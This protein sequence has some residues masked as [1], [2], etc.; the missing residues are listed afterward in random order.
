MEE[1][2]KTVTPVQY[3]KNVPTTRIIVVYNNDYYNYSELILII[4]LT[5]CFFRAEWNSVWLF[6][7]YDS[8]TVLYLCFKQEFLLLFSKD[9]WNKV[10]GWLKNRLKR[11]GDEI[12]SNKI[13]LW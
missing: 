3:A 6:N 8:L 12:G 5:V 7:F 1:R 2:D 4:Y 13:S 9:V 10:Y 11:F